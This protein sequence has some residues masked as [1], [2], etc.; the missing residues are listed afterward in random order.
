MG[1]I[2]A[3]GELAALAKLPANWR[4]VVEDSAVTQTEQADR[5]RGQGKLFE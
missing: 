4:S 1:D 2:S 5:Q 3:T